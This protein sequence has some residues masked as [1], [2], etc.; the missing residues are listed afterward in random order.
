MMR[1]CFLLVFIG[2]S[3]MAFS[4]KLNT[5]L[6]L[7]IYRKLLKADKADFVKVGESLGLSTDFDSLS[8]I[9][10]LQKQGFLFSKP[11]GEDTSASVYALHM[12]V[13]TLDKN[14][15]K[16]I[17]KSAKPVPDKAN[18]WMDSNYLYVEWDA[19]NPVSKEVWY[20]IVIYKKRE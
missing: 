14:N 18:T 8:N 19:E 17:L 12:L 6:D 1:I 3:Q 13:S 20:R 11:M 9:R 15:N 7:K 2:F 10:F 5:K 16:L 4:Q